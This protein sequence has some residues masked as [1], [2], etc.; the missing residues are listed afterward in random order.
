MLQLSLCMIVKNEEQV[1]ERCLDSVK[2]IVDEIIIADTGSTDNT[3]NIASK[4]TGHIYDFEWTDSFSDARNFA[5]SKASG[6]WILVLDADEY[7]DGDN[8]KEVKGQL[9]ETSESIDAFSTTI[10]NFAGYSG[11][12]IVQH[13]SLRIYRNDPNIKYVRTIH[14]QLIRED[15]EFKSDKSELIIYHSGYMDN[16]VKGKNKNSRN[17]KLIQKQTDVAGQAA[18]DYFNMGNEFLSAREV[19][20]ALEAFQK[21]YMQKADIR[22]AWVPLTVV[23]MVLCLI[24]LKRYNEALKVIYD[25]ELIWN[26]APEFKCLKANAFLAQNRR[27]EAKAELQELIENKENYK[28]F[29]RSIDYL[30]FHPY[31]LLGDIYNKEGNVSQAVENYAHVLSVNSRSYEAFY[32]LVSV[33]SK[34]CS[35]EELLKFINDNNLADEKKRMRLIKILLEISQLELAAAFIGSLKGNPGI[36]VGI[37]LKYKMLKD[38]YESARDYLMGIP[39]EDIV[40]ILGEGF[41]DRI[42]LGLLYLVKREQEVYSKITCAFDD[43]SMLLFLKKC[44]VNTDSN[45]DLYLKLLERSI[46]YKWFELFEKLLSEKIGDDAGIELGIG[47]MLNNHDFRELALEFYERVGDIK[48]LDEKAFENIVS[49]LK[50]EGQNENAV[51]FALKAID[52]GYTNFSVFMNAIQLLGEMGRKEIQKEIQQIAIGHYPDSRLLKDLK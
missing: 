52:M 31:M 34:Y 42:D 3:V 10:Y 29:I 27:Y 16:V 18:F 28:H 32:K 44:K 36:L 51:Q 43:K 17:V 23:Q 40:R 5:Q 24:D 13:R 47:H 25:A 30:E 14:E 50:E 1:L 21:A 8:L 33:L 20:K 49:T 39:E 38:G 37:I 41:I 7:V 45:K 48:R 26:N 22:F 11:E 6:K 2:D 46:R 4:Y 12:H 15:K 9:C 35:Q 19:E